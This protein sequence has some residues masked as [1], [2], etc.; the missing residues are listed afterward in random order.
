MTGPGDGSI[1]SAESPGSW[2]VRLDGMDQSYVDLDDPTRLVFDYVRRIGDLLDATAPRGAPLRV[3]HIGG[4]GLSLPRYVAVT[5]PGSRQ[6]VLE[7]DVALIELVRERLPLPRR[8]GVSVRPVDG[9]SGLVEVRDGWAEAVVVDA[10][11]GAAVPTDLLTVAGFAELRRVTADGSLV[12]VNLTDRAPF[13]AARDVV[14]TMRTAFADLV[15]GVE[16]ATWR[17]RRSGNLLVVAG[18]RPAA[19]AGPTYRWLVGDAVSSSVGGG[20][21][22]R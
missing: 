22:L 5:R 12:V 20:A 21:V 7:P 9:R 3:L 13:A 8:S 6:V 17:G 19:A 2:L 18:A 10:F 11:C 16:T 14:A 4:A 15:V 1:E